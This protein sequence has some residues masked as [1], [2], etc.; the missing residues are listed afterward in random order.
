MDRLGFIKL[1]CA[2][3]VLDACAAPEARTYGSTG[4]E[5]RI[6]DSMSDGSLVTRVTPGD[7]ISG[8][9]DTPVTGISR[10]T[11]LSL[12]SAAVRGCVSLIVRRRP[13]DY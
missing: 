5:Q 10:C 12:T 13:S 6:D 11:L 7:P 1:A 9:K 3:G 4:C 2:D 8:T